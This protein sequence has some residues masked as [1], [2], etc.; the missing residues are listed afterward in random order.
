MPSLV[1]QIINK[2]YE[3]KASFLDLGNC[4]LH[5]I[6]REIVKL[7][8][9][10]VHLNLGSRYIQ[11]GEY[12][13]STNKLGKNSISD[14]RRLY[15]ILIQLPNLKS[16]SLFHNNI[17][18]EGA[19]FIS[20]LSHLTELDLA[21][22]FVGQKGTKFI[23]ALSSLK[24][25]NLAFNTIGETGAMHLKDL[26]SL[27]YLDLSKNNIGDKGVEYIQELF[28]LES[29]NLESNQIGSSGFKHISK[30]PLLKLLDVEQNRISGH[31]LA[32]LNNL[33]NLVK[34]NL[35]KNQVTNDGAHYIGNLHS[36][37]SLNL[38][39]NKIGDDG[40]RHLSKLR[41]LESLNLD[42]NFIGFN[43]AEFIDTFTGLT[44][45]SLAHTTIG[46][47]GVFHVTE[48]PLLKSL[49]LA[50]NRISEVGAGYISRRG[51][52]TSLN[53]EQNNIRDTGAEYISRLS[54][55]LDLNLDSNNIHEIGAFHLSKLSSLKS[56]SLF[57]NA[58]GIKGAMHISKLLSLTKLNLSRNHIGDR[59]AEFISSL[60]SLKE[61]S[62]SDCNI[63]DSGLEHIY[64]LTHLSFLNLAGNAIQENGDECI[65]S[66]DQL[67]YLN[68]AKNKIKK[69]NPASKSTINSLHLQNNF[70]D[71][72]TINLINYVP[73]EIDIDETSP[74]II[75]KIF[76]SGN[77]IKNPPVEIL[78]KG[79]DAILEYLEGDLKPLNECKLIFVGDGS[80][81]KT[82]LMK[83]LVYDEYNKTEGT[84]H[85]INKIAW[86]GFENAKG[87]VIK[88]NLWDFGGQH[89]QH[90]LHQFFF[91]QRVVYVLVLDP[92]N[93][94]NA[95]YWLD[96]IDKLGSD[97][98]LIIAYNWKDKQDIHAD[99]LSNFRELRKT[100]KHLPTPIVLSCATGEGMDVF[101]QAVKSSILTNEGL[102]IKYPLPWFNIKEKL[103]T[104]IP[105]EK[106]YIKY[107][108]Y[109]SWC[110]EENYN[111]PRRR[112]T[113]LR[114]LDSVGSIVF[115]DKPVLNELQVL[116]P[117]WISTGAYAIITSPITRKAKGHLTWDNLLEIFS[118]E[119][120]IFSDKSIKIK[121]T[122]AQ[123]NFI[124]QLMRDYRLCEKNPLAEH[125]YLIPSAFG[126]KPNRNY[127]YAFGG[128]HYRLKFGSSFEM[129]I[130]HRF[131]AKNIKNI[132]N[133][134]YWHSGIY[135]KHSSSST[136]ALVETNKYSQVID[137]WINGEN[138]RG[139]WEVIRNDFREIF[140]MY[141]NFQVDEEVEYVSDGRVV[142][143]KYEEMITALNNGVPIIH[144]DVKTGIKNIDVNNVLEL[145]ESPTSTKRN[146]DS[147]QINIEISPNITV[148]HEFISSQ[149]INVN[150]Q[151]FGRIKDEKEVLMADKML[152]D[153]KVKRW[154][155]KALLILIISLL[156]TGFLFTIW[157][158]RLVFSQVAWIKFESNETLK[159]TGLILGAIWNG[160]IIK[161]C[162][163]R[164]FDP[165]KEIAYR[166]K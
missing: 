71:T 128:R 35:A 24:R 132:L 148:A 62:L 66:F 9:T 77:P 26:T 103:E 118:T 159:V 2:A 141:Q 39:E 131:I 108:E 38:A 17:K 50:G 12:I 73:V 122:E 99:F 88:V 70:I 47:L 117:E 10:L 75:D 13:Q 93:D 31:E 81:G 7:E 4:A 28:Q 130:I 139:M 34:L 164:L 119:K 87:E 107:H 102:N 65:S 22:N 29:L 55:L 160:F 41:K 140:N 153:N 27:T 162:Y 104:R 85:G 53:L 157:I 163:D 134:D 100:Y 91:T 110:E 144:Y 116:N 46:E 79:R 146:I 121:Y 155:R 145:F 142:F 1:S 43:G 151:G 52:L 135:F 37:K 32:S 165:S 105:I 80:V 8:Q 154:K 74:N 90:S 61:L 125:E 133:N 44:H 19:E 16:L 124:L 161:I 15:S 3:N 54:Q 42:R 106:H 51:S 113:L 82:S 20:Q 115:F 11:D 25:L 127:D 147:N 33:S 120:D 5:E 143:L 45:L 129:L 84:T 98:Q 78:R 60:Y 36:L 97:S 57:D 94:A 95:N 59:G 48:L 21:A 92:R 150:T 158:K 166:K 14:D 114:I 137:C 96:Q 69:F 56:L 136:F 112:R 111:D 138:I 23:S 156:I 149:V 89:I 64:K 40:I 6:P 72:L 83:R 49:N 109:E 63:G 30:L 126:E 67:S 152:E 86:K 101:F 123:F 58:V 18:H 68:L 76:L